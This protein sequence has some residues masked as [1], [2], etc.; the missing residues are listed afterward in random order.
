MCGM[1]CCLGGDS[2]L[3]ARVIATMQQKTL[4]SSAALDEIRQT[5]ILV[6]FYN[7]AGPWSC[8]TTP[9]HT[10]SFTIDCLKLQTKLLYK[11]LF[12]MTI[13]ASARTV[14]IDHLQVSYLCA[15]EAILQ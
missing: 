2:S 4:M 3:I 6:N 9:A 7:P 5:V 13:S 12:C 1:G 14:S 8:E 15:F 11:R 10:R